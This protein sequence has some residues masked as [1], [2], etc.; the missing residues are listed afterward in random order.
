MKKQAKLAAYPWLLALLFPACSTVEVQEPQ[1]SLAALEPGKA[2]TVVLSYYSRSEL[3]PKE[4]EFLNTLAEAHA[5][6]DSIYK[7]VTEAVHKAN[8][9][10]KVI[11][12]D[13][14]RRVAFPDLGFSQAPHSVES[15]KLLL[16]NPTFLNR[17]VPLGL[18]Y[19]VI[20]SSTDKEVKSTWGPGCGGGGYGAACLFGFVWDK[21][22][23]LGG[24]ILDLKQASALQAELSAT[25]SGKSWFSVIGIF[26][27]GFR[28][29]PLGPVACDGF[30][31]A[32]AKAIVSGESKP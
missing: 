6:E 8:P 32:V 28:L 20:A 23:Q 15:F 9:S 31:K 26:P 17:I 22:S 3:N 16:D 4:V 10:V 7:C 21:S 24:I 5:M 19:L 30:G 25:A 18:R 29:P 2:V 27:L 12:P 11:P 1:N 13:V 14:F